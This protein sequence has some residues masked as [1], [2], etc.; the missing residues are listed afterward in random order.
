MK[1]SLNGF[2]TKTITITD[3]VQDLVFKNISPDATIKVV[4]RRDGEEE[5]T[6][7][8]TIGFGKLV[9]AHQKVKSIALASEVCLQVVNVANDDAGTTDVYDQVVLNICQGEYVQKDSDTIVVYL[10]NL[11]KIT[12]DSEVFSVEGKVIG[13]KF[14]VL[15]KYSYIHT[16]DKQ[17]LD[18]RGKHFL[19]VS[20]DNVPEEIVVYYEGNQSKDIN[21]DLLKA[22]NKSEHGLVRMD[23]AA[24]GDITPIF[25]AKEIFVLD[26]RDVSKLVIKDEVKGAN[27][28]VYTLTY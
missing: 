6:P 8:P 25:G 17:E 22:I 23:V 21:E 14:S 20:P 27:F 12:A 10:S 26:I 4:V 11:S 24:N 9:E 5:F 2:G 13:N 16:K 28:D 18:V 19:L 1:E 7:I 15:D 3:N